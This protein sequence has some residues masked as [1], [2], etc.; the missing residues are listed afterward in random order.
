MVSQGRVEEGIGRVNETLPRETRAEPRSTSAGPA[1]SGLS[2]R[3]QHAAARETRLETRAR[4]T[5]RI[6]GAI[7][8]LA[9]TQEAV[10]VAAILCAWTRTTGVR[11]AE[12]SQ[13]PSLD[14]LSIPR[15]RVIWG[16]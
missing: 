13:H 16:N 8:T 2:S 11:A 5:A 6:T 14:K 3:A 4:S 10:A 7:R 9:E 15:G 12:N 1:G